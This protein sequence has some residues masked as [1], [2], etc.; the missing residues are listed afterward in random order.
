MNQQIEQ[1]VIN[2]FFMELQKG[3]NNNNLDALIN[4][5]HEEFPESYILQYYVG[6]F[7]TKIGEFE[8]AEEQYLKCINISR[9]FTEPYFDVCDYYIKIGKIEKAET[10]LM[11]IFEKKTMNPKESNVA[12]RFS[13][14]FE[15]D[16]RICSVLCPALIQQQTEKSHKKA[17]KLYT[18]C[19]NVL[20]KK[21][22]LNLI[23]TQCYKNICAGLASLY[24]NSDQELSYTYYS[25]SLKIKEKEPKNLSEQD[26]LKILDNDQKNLQGL[27][28]AENYLMNKIEKLPITV[29]EL[30]HTKTKEKI[31][32]SEIKPIG[33]KIRLGTSKIRLGYLS[34]DFNKNA[35]GLFC[36][37]LLN[38]YDKDKFEI[39]CFYTKQNEDMFTQIFKSFVKNW[40]P[41]FH[42][43]S[44]SLCSFIKEKEIDILI[45]LSGHGHENRISSLA[46]KPAPIII[47]Y[48][49]FPGSTRLKEVD[50]RIVDRYTDPDEPSNEITEKL[51][52]MPR[53]F[54]CYTLFLNVPE[55]K[56]NYM[57]SKDKIYIGIFNKSSKQN[58]FILNIWKDIAQ[59]NKKCVFC[60]K[61]DSDNPLQKDL[62]KDFPQNTVEY[63]PFT[64]TLDSYL[65]FFN[66]I[67]FC[68]DTYP[69]SGTTTTCASLLMGVPTF[70]I[71][72]KTN[73]RHVSNVSA[74]ILINNSNEGMYDLSEYIC[75]K[76][77]DYKESI[78]KKSRALLIEKENSNFVSK[79]NERRLL[80]RKQF[81]K[82]M[83]SD[84]FMKEYESELIKLFNE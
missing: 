26:Y 82:T 61:L 73:R 6:H 56:I 47:T 4:R 71:Y 44:Q 30:F 21:K 25:E 74:S 39:F 83:D 22:V 15:K 53:L 57:N 24:I 84:R 1:S 3:P 11:N 37:A 2:Q 66:K 68:V 14:N 79:E 75:D 48:L 31:S 65:E 40:F 45:D 78:I 18:K 67:D 69:Y 13:H 42:L 9:F 32:I 70:T 72:N 63:F 50:Y 43:D 5:I 80:I 8:S 34:P 62:Y 16:L 64:E 17:I 59:K 28:V 54:I 46:L 77:K 19:I 55:P 51:I 27:L 41:V 7:Y 35:V 58:K 12:K 29:D 52:Y 60:I 23:E 20:R 81:Y 33:D 36:E 38:H 10:L 49:G 76:T